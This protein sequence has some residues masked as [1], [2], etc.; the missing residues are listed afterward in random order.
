MEGTAQC[1]ASTNG[2]F[3][4]KQ[5]PVSDDVLTR[6]NAA[7]AELRRP[8]PE[9]GTLLFETLHPQVWMDHGPFQSRAMQTYAL[10]TQP[11]LFETLNPKLWMAH[12]PFGTY[13]GISTSPQKLNLKQGP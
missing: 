5:F 2:S 6:K 8:M 1:N 3:T 11:C 7:M 12:G 4:L 10:D 9:H 13:P